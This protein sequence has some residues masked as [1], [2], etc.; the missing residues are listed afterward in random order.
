MLTFVLCACVLRGGIVPGDFTGDGRV[1][2][3]DIP[4]FAATLVCND[5]CPEPC[6][7]CADCNRDGEV[8]GADV[9]AFVDLLLR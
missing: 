6:P 9:A 1:G 2:P 4:G 5:G 7:P 8:N 3:D